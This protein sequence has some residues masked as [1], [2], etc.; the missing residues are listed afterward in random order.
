[1]ISSHAAIA[2]DNA[3]LLIS[4]KQALEKVKESDRLKSNFYR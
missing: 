3:R 1:V 4:T 2:I